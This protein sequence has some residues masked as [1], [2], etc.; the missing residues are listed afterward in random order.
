MSQNKLYSQAQGQ[1]V[2]NADSVYCHGR[3]WKSHVQ[4]HG[5]HCREKVK[6]KDSYLVYMPLLLLLLH[7]APSV[8]NT[9]VGH[10][11]LL[12]EPLS[13]LLV[14]GSVCQ[15]LPQNGFYPETAFLLH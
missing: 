15:H 9:N 1:W 8:Y 11:M 7:T 3:H 13:L 14:N 5:F 4:K 10:W 2:W 12:L 6:S